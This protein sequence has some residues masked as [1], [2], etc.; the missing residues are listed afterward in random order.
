MYKKH[1][2]HILVQTHITRKN[3]SKNAPPVNTVRRLK[4]E[5]KLKYTTQKWAQKYEKQRIQQHMY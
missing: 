5:N 4:T 2:E 1:Q 3:M